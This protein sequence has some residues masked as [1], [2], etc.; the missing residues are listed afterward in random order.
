MTALDQIMET[1]GAIVFLII[2]GW[3]TAYAYGLVGDRLAGGFRWRPEFRRTLRWI[4]P[5]LVLLC[6]GALVFLV[7]Q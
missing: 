2:G 3:G 1:V 6:L 7:R 5:V 4:G